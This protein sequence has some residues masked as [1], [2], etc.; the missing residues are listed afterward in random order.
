M[1][2]SGTQGADDI[3]LFILVGVI[4]IYSVDENYFLYTSAPFY[5]FCIFDSTNIKAKM[6]QIGNVNEIGFGISKG[7]LI[8]ILSCL[9]FDIH[10]CILHT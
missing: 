8:L 6:S 2:K 5:I 1:A 7:C 3:L 4:F 10:T 9:L